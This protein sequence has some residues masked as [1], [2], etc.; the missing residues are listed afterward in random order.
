[1]PLEGSTARLLP[2]FQAFDFLKL[3]GILHHSFS[4]LEEKK[5]GEKEIRRAFVNV[6]SS[7]L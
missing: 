3:W 6:N 7:V 4:G 1:V 5:K 2:S